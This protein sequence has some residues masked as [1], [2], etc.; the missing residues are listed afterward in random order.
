M[1][2][3]DKLIRG[4][5]PS[6]LERPASSE[7]AR[8][9]TRTEA[10]TAE[11]ASALHLIAGGLAAE[12]IQ[13]IDEVKHAIAVHA[14]I[15]VHRAAACSQRTADV[16][17]LLQNVVHLE[18]DGGIPFQESLRQLCIPDKLVTVHT[19]VRISSTA[20]VGNVGRERHVPRHG[21]LRIG[22]VG[23]GIGL[24]II[25]RRQFILLY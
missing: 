11:A 10:R 16:T 5:I 2:Q 3:N 21:N 17:L 19:A 20:L 12:N 24:L 15:F 4:V 18:A 23:E 14:V 22:T 13:T 8:T 25:V 6:A 9:M 1:Y 7:T